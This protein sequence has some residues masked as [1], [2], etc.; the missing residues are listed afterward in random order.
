[1]D[2]LNLTAA[3]DVLLKFRSQ[4]DWSKFHT[5]KNLAISIAIEAAELMEHFQWK[6]DDEAKEYLSSSKFDDVKDEIAD[7]ASYLLLLSHDLGIDLNQA[8]LDKVK[9]NELKYPV[10]KCRG[11]NN[12]Y[13]DL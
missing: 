3:L 13:N 4:R 6:T 7:I 5:P 9:K 12:K 10:A 11:K 2:S 1:M 8:I